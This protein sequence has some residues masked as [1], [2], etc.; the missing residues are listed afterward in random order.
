MFVMV[1]VVY[2]DRGTEN[3]TQYSPHPTKEKIYHGNKFFQVEP[4][5]DN[6]KKRFFAV[7]TAFALIIRL[8]VLY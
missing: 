4:E 7:V 8:A 6:D 1:Q 2:I 5:P 3:F